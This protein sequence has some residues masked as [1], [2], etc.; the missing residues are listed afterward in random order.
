V[1]AVH[2]RYF[3]DPACP[4]SWAAEPAVRRIEA[5][6]GGQVSITY[7][8]AGLAREFQRPLDVLREVL[9]ASLASAMP[10]DP[11]LWLD[12]PPASSH[13][14]CQ[15]VKAAAEQGL[16]RPY[17]RVLREGVMLERRA[18]DSAPALVD[19]ARTV[20][21]LDAARFEIDLRSHAIVE[22]FGADLE[23]ARDV[24]LPSFEVAGGRW[25]RD[26]HRVEPLRAALVDAGAQPGP[27]PGVEEA[28]GR[29][30]RMATPEVA[31]VCDLPGP[32]AAAE[33]WR[34]ATE[35]RVRPERHLGG[36]IWALA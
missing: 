24:P 13:P 20:P 14:A 7:V 22:A 31:A 6:F 18:M 25:I 26:E 9:D 23:R 1:G 10:V 8:M 33:L 2:V 5:E 30:G 27:L 17:L 28:L 4:W 19:A 3:T 11:R 32:R 12:R 15:A 35:W 21:G 34:L 16:D 36:E 29:F